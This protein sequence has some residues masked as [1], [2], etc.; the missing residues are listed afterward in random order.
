VEV[1]NFAPIYNGPGG[2]GVAAECRAFSTSAYTGFT[3]G[4]AY[5]L[6]FQF[7][8]SSQSNNNQCIVFDNFR[9]NGTNSA[10]TLPVSF[11]NIN[12]RR[13]GNQAELIWNVAGEREVNYYEI[14]RSTDGR[15]FVKIGEVP[16]RAASAYAYVDAQPLTGASF[17]RVRNVDLDGRS[18]YSYVVRYNANRVAANMQVYPN[19]VK[20]EAVI[21]HNEYSSN[22]RF[23]I[24]DMN[25]RIVKTIVPLRGVNNTRINVG[26]LNTGVYVLRIENGN[27][28]SETT[29]FVKQ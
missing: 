2:T 23:S 20:G 13:N 7:T 17:Y 11:T 29:T 25:G 9:T 4:E 14:E 15:N 5:R 28:Y 21:E 6:I 26:D 19:P 10:I 16:A 27:G 22:A 3:S 8:A 24:I 18:K 12:V 1:A